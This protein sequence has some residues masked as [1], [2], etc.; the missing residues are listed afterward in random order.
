MNNSNHHKLLVILITFNS[1]IYIE[2]CFYSIS[3]Q[4]YNDFNLLIIDNNSQ[5]NTLEIIKN[6][7]SKYP[8][9]ANKTEIIDLNSNIGFSRAVNIGL[10]KAINKI[11]LCTS[12]LLINHDTYFDKNLFKYGMDLLIINKKAGACCPKILS[13]NN[14]LWWQGTRLYSVNDIIWG[15]NHRISEFIQEGGKKV[16]NNVFELEILNGCAMFIKVSAIKTAGMFNEK[17]FMYVDDLEYSIRLKKFGYKLLLF[18]NSFVYHDTIS[19]KKNFI[20]EIKREV[21]EINSIAEYLKEY[22][23]PFVFYIWLIKLPISL[24][25]MFIRRIIPYCYFRFH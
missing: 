10:R 12:V 4:T 24:G 3:K 23:S 21:M 8:K 6:L 19:R 17:Y 5:D 14:T 22:H 25:F 2:K 1:E 20:M 15:I 16:A 18:T 7:L 11:K 9:L 13:P